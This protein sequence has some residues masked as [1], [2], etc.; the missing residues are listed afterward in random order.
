MPRFV[1]CF[2][3]WCSRRRWRI[4]TSLS[5]HAFD[6]S[7]SQQYPQDSEVIGWSCTISR[8]SNFT[9]AQVHTFCGD[10]TSGLFCICYDCFLKKYL[11]VFQTKVM[12]FLGL[13]AIKY[14][15]QWRLWIENIR[16]WPGT[17]HRE[18][19]DRLRCY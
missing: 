15:R 9:R 11:I 8:L 1:G 19:N 2:P 6:G 14:C 17:T 7:W 13:K 4:P 10:H 12:P 16:F 18:W 5:R 3:S